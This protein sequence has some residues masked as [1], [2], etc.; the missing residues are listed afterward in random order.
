MRNESHF[1]QSLRLFSIDMIFDRYLLK[2]IDA[3][4]D[5]HSYFSSIQ[6]NMHVCAPP[7]GSAVSHPNRIQ[8]E[9]KTQRPKYPSIFALQAPALQ[10]SSRSSNPWHAL[11]WNLLRKIQIHT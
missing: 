10:I 6:R 7:L 8:S 3:G 2:L 9:V 4:R 1:S 5:I 11:G